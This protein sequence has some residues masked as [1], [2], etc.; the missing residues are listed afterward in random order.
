LHVSGQHHKVDVEGLHEFAKP[1]FSLQFGSRQNGNL[2]E[3]DPVSRG[4]RSEIGM[5][6]HDGH[7]VNGKVAVLSAVQEVG[8]TVI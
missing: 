5:V 7:D 1:G 8:E 2:I 3:R 4:Q 6:T